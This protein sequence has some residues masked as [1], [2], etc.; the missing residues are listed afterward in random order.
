MNNN[1]LCRAA[2]EASNNAHAPYSH[3]KVGAA[4]LTSKGKIYTGCNIENAS[5]SATICA[6]RTALFNAVSCGEKEF[7][8]LAL[9]ASANEN[10]SNLCVPCGVC[11]QALSEFCAPTLP[12]LLVKNENEYESRTL[13]DFLPRAFELK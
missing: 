10:T 9:Y 7:C 2:I 8:A 1:E 6:E 11:L 4:I 3:F 12:I 5:Y 13:G